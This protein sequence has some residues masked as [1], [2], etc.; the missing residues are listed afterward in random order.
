MT[1]LVRAQCTTCDRME[2]VVRE[3]CAEVGVGWE[4]VDIDHAD[5]DLRGEFGDRIPVTLVDGEEHATWRVEAAALRT[6]LQ[7]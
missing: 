5:A 2:D 3:V 7:A 1:V 6:A 4:R